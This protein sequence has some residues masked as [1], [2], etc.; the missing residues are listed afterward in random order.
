MKDNHSEVKGSRVP[1]F[2]KMLVDA[3]VVS[4]KNATV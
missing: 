2:T 1:H 3:V 4:L